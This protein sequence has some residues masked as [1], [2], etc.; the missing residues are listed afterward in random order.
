MLCFPPYDLALFGWIALAP[1]VWL[2][3]RA[4]GARRGALLA[5][6][7]AAVAELHTAHWVPPS[8][9]A[10]FGM[11]ARNAWIVHVGLT[12]HVAVWFAVFG[13]LVV[14]LV[15]AGLPSLVVV[16]CAFVVS[17][18]GRGLG[19]SLPWELLGQSQW[20]VPAVLQLAEWGG[21]PALSFALA[22][23]ST[24]WAESVRAAL[25]G[26]RRRGVAFAA[27]GVGLPLLV[28]GGGW[29]RLRAV[30]AQ[31]PQPTFRVA[32]VQAAIPQAERWDERTRTRNLAQHLRLTAQ[33]TREGADLVVWSETAV[34]FF[35]ED[36]APLR[37]TLGQALGG[38]PERLVL[39]GLPRRVHRDGREG[40]ANAAVLVDGAGRER[41]H[42]D[43]IHLVPIAEKDPELLLR[44]PGARTVLANLVEGDPFVGGHDPTPLETPW[45]RLGA[46]ICFESIYP[47]AARDTVERGA[48][49]LV[50]I[51][52]DAYFATRGAV[53][54]HLAATVPRA[55]ETRR[56]LVRVVNGGIGAVVSAAG[57]VVL[58]ID[59]DETRVAIVPLAPGHGTTLYLRVGWALPWAAL[60]VVMGALGT[61]ALRRYRA[62]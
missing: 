41:G 27:V 35:P 54:Q 1:L 26:E 42:Y 43:K 30:E 48:D 52:N 10:G 8:L 5:F 21:V 38:D 59:R 20:Q 62:R 28:A 3:L 37:R 13:A 32:L 49:V 46:L 58:R 29:L 36:P 55:V 53:E 16:P 44:L 17:E 4:P 33:A 47:E 14:S 45:A 34:D 9:E 60:G 6:V 24:A 61:L 50:N 39:L 22:A 23:T 7:F 40:W 18:L 51:S 56:P 15:R 57:R 11:S 25:G 19:D 2:L 12:L 31:A